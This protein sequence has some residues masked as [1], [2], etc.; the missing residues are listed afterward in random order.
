MA[1]DIPVVARPSNAIEKVRIL[2]ASVIILAVAPRMKPA[3]R[4]VA[5]AAVEAGGRGRRS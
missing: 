4:E 3:A 2:E 1:G 5:V